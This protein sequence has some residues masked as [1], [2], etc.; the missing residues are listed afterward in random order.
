MGVEITING[1]AVDVD[2]ADVTNLSSLIDRVA[3]T[4]LRRH[5][6]IDGLVVN[7]DPIN[8]SGAAD[9]PDPPVASLTDVAFTTIP[10]PAQKLIE[11]I[12][13]M[14]EYLAGLV[15]Q[16][17]NVGDAFR[18]GGPEEA[19]AMLNL[20][21][22]G[23]GALA[24]LISSARTLSRTDLSELTVAG[25]SLGALEQAGIDVLR[26]LK[27]AQ[28]KRD[29]VTVADLIEYELAPILRRWLP[30]LPHVRLRLTTNDQ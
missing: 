5:E 26:E 3:A 29:W 11:M 15:D 2:L 14:E 4:H 19:N 13:G 23:V 12:G 27:A 21:L 16:L 7:G 6:L 20:A 30:M 10:D 9:A 17:P 28:E 18:M 1:A 24:D 22:E 8:M 25:E